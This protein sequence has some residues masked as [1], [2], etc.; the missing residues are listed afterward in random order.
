MLKNMKIGKKLITCFILVGLIASISG[1]VSIFTTLYTNA[2]YSKAL[3]NYGF[4]QGDVGKALL[5][6]SD[7][8]TCARDVV[9][10]TQK[11]YIDAAKA[12]LQEDQEKYNEFVK[13]IEPTLLNQEG[14]DLFNKA[15][16]AIKIYSAK[17]DEVVTLGDTLD[18]EQSE[19]ARVMMAEEMDPLYDNA[20]NAWTDL[21]KFKVD[22]GNALSESLTT[23]GVIVVVVSITLVLVSMFVAV[24][25]GTVIAKGISK[26]VNDIVNAANEIVK[27]NLGVE[28]EVGTNDE[29]GELAKMFGVM[30]NNL[31]AIISDLGYC[32][33][34][35]ANG[36]FDI[37]TKA[38][39]KYI[40]EYE[41][42]LLS[43]RGI[44]GK[45]SRALGEINEA[46]VQVSEASS[47]MADGSTTLAEGATEQ[48][49]SVEELLAT[50]EVITNE[51]ETNAESSEQTANLMKGIGMDAAESNQQMKDLIQAME[52]ISESSKGIG[53]IINTIEEIASQ[54]NLLSLNAAI[55]AA[56]AGEAGKGFAVVANEI[57]SLAEQSAMAVNNTREL[58]ETALT[59]VANGS[60]MTNKTAEALESVAEKIGGAVELAE[61]SKESSVMQAGKMK[62]I[63]QVLEQISSVIQSNSA[64]AEESSA[65]SEELSAQAYT[66]ADLVGQ[67]K[68][69]KE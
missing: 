18:V 42:L 67:F 27:G 64:T 14:K 19:E 39:D 4:V 9:S 34:E 30:T 43:L 31:Q 33:G 53:A 41:A 7:T 46:T 15:Q 52:R 35:M 37:K 54:T 51:T 56:R 17:R 20:Y 12:K 65:T 16:E 6:L 57:R 55:E 2:E 13:A 58:I 21:M 25:L 32:L 38:G 26:P 49:S 68:L 23:Q 1:I 69:K 48:A 50:V 62:E 40:G 59:E 8:Q 36:N 11:E 44:N 61:T 24:L 29:I 45:L 28:V 66:L 5:M 3:I 22:K 10:N 63:N 60:S 47:Q